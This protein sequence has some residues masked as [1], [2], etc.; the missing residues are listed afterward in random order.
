MGIPI[1]QQLAEELYIMIINCCSFDVENTT[2]VDNDKYDDDKQ[3]D[4]QEEN[5]W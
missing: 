2:T 4:S 3:A 1:E 5:R